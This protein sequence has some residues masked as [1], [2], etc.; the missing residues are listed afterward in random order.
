[1]RGALPHALPENGG[2]LRVRFGEEMGTNDRKKIR[3]DVILA[4]VLL[5]LAAAAM[6]FW[7][8]QKTE[9]DFAVVLIDG[10]ETA[11]YALDSDTEVEIT[12]D[13]GGTNTLVIRDGEAF[14]E[15]AN[16]PDLVCAG[17]RAISRVGETIVCLPHK[18][19]IKITAS[20]DAG[21]VDMAA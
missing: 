2:F 1:M 11:R 19:V 15:A 10:V 3:N 13:G 4:V 5:L 17:H 20:T 9:G 18:L 16:C 21:G 14:V 7:Q 8:L 12:T 6:L